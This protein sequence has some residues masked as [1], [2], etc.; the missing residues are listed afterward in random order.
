MRLVNEE[1]VE[2]MA[3]YLAMTSGDKWRELDDAQRERYREQA[4]ATILA[5]AQKAS[6]DSGPGR[7]HTT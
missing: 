5:K 6:G 4:R 7:G 1:H 2:G 3:E